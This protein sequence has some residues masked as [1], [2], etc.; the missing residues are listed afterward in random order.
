MKLPII[1]ELVEVSSA[2]IEMNSG[3]VV[4]LWSHQRG[5]THVH[6]SKKSPN[7]SDSDHIPTTYTII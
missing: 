3:V 1:V 6:M 7:N 2:F 4:V 5:L